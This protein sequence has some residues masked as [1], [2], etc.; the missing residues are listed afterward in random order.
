MAKA[1]RR[2]L[3]EEYPEDDLHFWKIPKG[4]VIWP[5]TSS[6]E[7]SPNYCFFVGQYPLKYG[8][9]SRVMSKDFNKVLTEAQRC[10]NRDRHCIYV[11]K[12]GRYMPERFMDDVYNEAWNCRTVRPEQGVKRLARRRRRSRIEIEEGW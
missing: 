4:R 12:V 8:K 2:K 11:Y 9:F 10:A 5:F 6:P 3:K 7:E 1:R